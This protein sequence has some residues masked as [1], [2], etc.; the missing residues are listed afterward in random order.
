[1]KEIVELEKMERNVVRNWEFLM[2]FIRL[3]DM[4]K[5]A[6]AAHRQ[7]SFSHFNGFIIT[8]RFFADDEARF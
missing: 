2:E 6:I 1:M 8:A 4:I 3:I 5:E 7:T